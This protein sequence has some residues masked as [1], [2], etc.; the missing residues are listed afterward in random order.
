MSTFTLVSQVIRKLEAISLA[1]GET[2]FDAKVQA[3]FSQLTQKYFK[4]SNHSVEID[5][6]DAITHFCYVFKYVAPHADYLARILA[7]AR[8]KA[9]K[10]LFSRKVLRVACIGGGPG[11]DLIGLLKYL[12]GRANEDGIKEIEVTVYDKEEA[13]HEVFNFVL[14]STY[15][16]I[17][18][19]A[20]FGTLDVTDPSAWNG[21]TF[22]D[23]DL[24]I[25]SFLVSE[26]CRL[27]L[28]KAAKGFW[29][30]LLSSMRT[31][32]LFVYNDSSNDTFRDY[33]DAIIATSG[34]FKTLVRFDK[35]EMHCQDSTSPIADYI[36]RFDHRPKKKGDLAFRVLERQ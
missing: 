33:F 9:K 14:A 1:A 13:W 3:T 4:L 32:S 29:S 36:N 19:T 22:S 2:N 31:G 15:S 21:I 24:I 7:L 5:Y 28:G 12:A 35:T 25:S 8:T 17:K 23:Y 26:I 16:N 11:T 30:Q 6:G 18:I 20:F 34:N 27:K 10:P